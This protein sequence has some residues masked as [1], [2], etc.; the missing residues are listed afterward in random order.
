MKLLN[1]HI[2]KYNKNVSS[3]YRRVKGKIKDAKKKKNGEERNMG[4]EK[5]WT[6]CSEQRIEN[7]C[8]P[9]RIPFFE[10]YDYKIY[11]S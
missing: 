10:V 4:T 2:S 8:T 3:Y 11:G 7:A 6:E 9:K 1:K 5:E